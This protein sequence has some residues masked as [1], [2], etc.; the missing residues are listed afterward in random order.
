MSAVTAVR[1]A[2]L[3]GPLKGDKDT[4]KTRAKDKKYFRSCVFLFFANVAAPTPA[5]VAAAVIPSLAVAAAVVVPSLA[6]VAAAVV[7]SPAA[8]VA[9]CIAAVV[10]TAAA[11]VFA[12]A[13]A[14]A[15][16]VASCGL[17]RD[18]EIL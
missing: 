14:V 8:I 15:A 13:A 9:V 16:A 6:V 4:G 10:S 3:R 11:G 17:L 12:V 5:V 7:P 18:A 2:T 1:Y